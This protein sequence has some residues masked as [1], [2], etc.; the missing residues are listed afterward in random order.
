MSW[1]DIWKICLSVVGS[2]GGVGIIFVAIL[3]YSSNLIA[4]KL[5]KKYDL[6]LSKELE[7]YKLSLE[8][9][10]YISKTR[11]DTEFTIY[12]N[13]SA[14]F[15]DA[16]KSVNILIPA[17][18]T[19]V[20]ADKEE[21]RKA[22]AKHYDDA[23]SAVVK[24]QDELKSNIPFISEDIYNGYDELL[25]L[26]S[27]QLDAYTDRF[28]ITDFRPQEEKES[29]ALEDYKRTREINDKWTSLNNTIREYLD[30]LDVIS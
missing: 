24:A 14:S 26:S 29:F 17:G 15:A 30:S 5:S 19:T 28:L 22:D 11:F 4:D 8:S 18:Y 21:R 1:P 27:L 2:V 6:K 13:L 3:K 20:P 12:R 23:L 7:L 25:R 10:K 16:I 9:K